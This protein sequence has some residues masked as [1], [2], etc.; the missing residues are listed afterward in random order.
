MM[1]GSGWASAT[2]RSGFKMGNG[3]R[4]CCRIKGLETL[5][6]IV[7]LIIAQCCFCQSEHIPQNTEDRA[8]NDG[9]RHNQDKVLTPPRT[10]NPERQ[11]IHSGG[12]VE[13]AKKFLGIVGAHS[14]TKGPTSSPRPAQKVFISEDNKHGDKHQGPRVIFA[15]DIPT[16]ERK[17][18]ADKS[19][20]EVPVAEEI[21]DE[22]PSKESKS[23]STIPDDSV[24]KDETQLKLTQETQEKEE[25]QKQKK[26]EKEEEN[27]EETGKDKASRV[28]FISDIE[29][30][31]EE[32]ISQNEPA[33]QAHEDEEAG[34]ASQDKDSGQQDPKEDKSES[35]D[36][37]EKRAEKATEKRESDE[38][39]K[40]DEP[41]D[42]SEKADQYVMSAI[43][44]DKGEAQKEKSEHE[45][46][47]DDFIEIEVPDETSVREMANFLTE[48][49]RKVHET[50]ESKNVDRVSGK[51]DVKDAQ[52]VEKEVEEEEETQ[53]ALDEMDE[54]LPPVAGGLE[55]EKEVL[56]AIEARSSSVVNVTISPARVLDDGVHNVHRK[57]LAQHLKE[58]DDDHG[59]SGGGGGKL[60]HF[61]DAKEFFNSIS[62]KNFTRIHSARAIQ[63]V[64]GEAR[65]RDTGQR[66]GSG[67]GGG[68]GGGKKESEGGKE[69]KGREETRPS[70]VKRKLGK[71]KDPEDV[72]RGKAKEEKEGGKEE[73]KN[74]EGEG[75]KEK[76]SESEDQGKESV[77]QQSEG[78]QTED[79]GDGKG[80][81]ETSSK[82][83]EEEG[84]GAD[85]DQDKEEP[86]ETKEKKKKKQ[87][88]KPLDTPTPVPEERAESD[89]NED[90][91]A[92]EFT[93]TEP[94][95]KEKNIGIVEEPEKADL[96]EEEKKKKKRKEEGREQEKEKGPG[97]E[98]QEAEA[99]AEKEELQDAVSDKKA[100]EEEPSE[101]TE[102]KEKTKDTAEE[103]KEEQKEEIPKESAKEEESQDKAEDAKEP[104]GEEKKQKETKAAKEK[105]ID[106][107]KGERPTANITKADKETG[108]PEKAKKKQ[109][110]E[111]AKIK[112]T[113]EGAEE[114]KADKKEEEKSPDTLETY[115]QFT[116]RVN[117]EKKN[118]VNANGHSGNGHKGPKVKSKNY[119]SPDCGSKL[120]SANPEA[121]HASKVI[122]SNRDEYMLNKCRD[123]IWFIIELCESIR[124]QKFDIA[125]FELFSN[126]PKEIQVSGSHRY[127]SRDW[128]S[129]GRFTAQ[130]GNRGVQSFHVDT[131]DFYKYVKVEVLSHY[132]SE[133]FCPIS[134]F[135]IYG[136]S[137]FEVI[138]TIEDVSE[139]SEDSEE[140]FTEAVEEENSGKKHKDEGKPSV[141]PAVLKNMFT[142][143]LDVIKRGYRP[144][145]ISTEPDE[146]CYSLHP[147]FAMESG[148]C[149][150]A[151]TLNYILSCYKMEYEALMLQPFVS[152]TVKNSSFCRRLASVM[153]AEP[154]VNDSVVYDT[155][156]NNSYVCVMLSPKHVLAMCFMQDPRIVDSQTACD[157]SDTHLPEN[158]STT[159]S[160]I[161]TTSKQIPSYVKN[162]V[163]NTSSITRADATD[164]NISRPSEVQGLKL[165]EIEDG[166]APAEQ[167]SEKSDEAS[168]TP[169]P[170]SGPS[171]PQKVAAK[172]PKA[173]GNTVQE[174]VAK[175]MESDSS[176]GETLEPV[177]VDGSGFG[178]VNLE[179]EEFAPSE[180]L[181]TVAP[182]P[183]SS[184]PP[185]VEPKQ[186]SSS[187]TN[188]ESIVV[189]LSNKIK[190]LEYNM[191]ISSQYLEE[192]SRR[193]KRQME[194]MQK[195]FN[196]TIAAL[197]ATSRQAYERDQ[198]HQRDIKSLE[199][200]LGNVSNILEKLVE[201][202][203]TLAH[204]VVEQHLLLMVVEVVVLCVVFTI[205]HRRRIADIRQENGAL[206]ERRAQ[207]P[208]EDP[209]SQIGLESRRCNFEDQIPSRV[210]R[211][212]VDS[213]TRERA[214]RPRRRRP[215][216]EALNISGTYQDLLIIE[217]AIP[218]LMD[219][220]VDH[221]KKRKSTSGTLKRSKSNASIVENSTLSSRRAKRIEKLNKSSAGVLFCGDKSESCSTPITPLSSPDSPD[222]S[223]IPYEPFYNEQDSVF[224]EML[225]E[226]DPC[227]PRPFIS[228]LEPGGK[229]LVDTE[230]ITSKRHSLPCCTNC[231]S[232]NKKSGKLSKS[233][234]L[235]SASESIKSGKE[236]GKKVK[237]IRKTKDNNIESKY[238]SSQGLEQDR[239]ND[240]DEVFSMPNGTSHDFRSHSNEFYPNGHSSVH[241]S[242][243]TKINGEHGH[244]YSYSPNSIY[245]DGY[246]N[247]IDSHTPLYVGK[248]FMYTDHDRLLMSERQKVIPKAKTKVKLRSDNWEWYSSQ[249]PG[250]SSSETVST[251]SDSSN[252][253]RKFK[254]EEGQVAGDVCNTEKKVKKKKSKVRS[255]VLTKE[256]TIPERDT[257]T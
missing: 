205:C 36:N 135:R 82:K 167:D 157:P 17:P 202:R 199:E 171:Q 83:E 165:I 84:V 201:E 244:F 183:P 190:A 130:E 194:E 58:K 222:I 110:A 106:E 43:S 220:M 182:P 108:E 213:I 7:I 112:K 18:K 246:A 203:E 115:S 229:V 192:L 15:E 41:M 44:N 156:C 107:E 34:S 59:R 235:C 39:K 57:V 122:H 102:E 35:K 45:K 56:S 125:N 146:R 50:V 155:V 215:S 53:M 95:E 94:E 179:E 139:D 134:L 131:E 42:L 162:A 151:G 124:P 111:S 254:K 160:D 49:R 243:D 93:D 55:V 163:I 169:S 29:E 72:E 60:T 80:T 184:T 239:L 86:E 20:V 225:E 38:N 28:K 119:A 218:I 251:C 126:L 234:S 214:S 26:V 189:R 238:F 69:E 252:R 46:S 116:Q 166:Q 153:C 71:G 51:S 210:R 216:E 206:N 137:E 185:P 174:K 211:R 170:D 224:Y 48:L 22:K 89:D 23:S 105:E 248:N 13:N 40:S 123:K 133:F 91:Q 253:S 76:E 79:D 143:V 113:K 150:M 219:S 249:H 68:G 25:K 63:L 227:I 16:S 195:Q 175:E 121:T 77:E 92:E 181:A 197:N 98:E 12:S 164:A 11:V 212:S 54:S 196:L 96:S 132:G 4:R 9:A 37:E 103:Q 231:D 21:I 101:A 65:E 187:P 208:S 237:K 188:K 255:P 256:D 232:Q 241:F 145:S 24:S 78:A 31:T 226:G 207:T 242:E 152:F 66:Q 88:K 223:G 144:S 154:E 118:D 127:P 158:F 168:Q 27:T 236:K 176:A 87:D 5:A 147:K 138:D 217:P 257:G 136:L 177:E 128:S 61:L 186:L 142:G 73:T 200:Q 228:E 191:S 149:S 221:K 74:R 180:D 30:I 114:G 47:T 90:K 100:S 1:F 19:P 81:K 247:G 32:I 233:I 141:I 97:P 117:A 6:F 67:G 2:N 8:Q 178:E 173:S 75:L 62:S 104:E 10:S 204:T 240:L 250:G 109:Q 161:M 140:T 198:E 85:A 14:G 172:E 70:D 52:E 209:E 99:E 230:P 3:P 120:M 33:D 64:E 245:A 148:M 129:L 193:Y 159:S